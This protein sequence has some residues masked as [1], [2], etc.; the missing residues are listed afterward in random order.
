[1]LYARS[2]PASDST[3]R[4]LTFGSDSVA[5]MFSLVARWVG[6]KSLSVCFDCL[7]GGGHARWVAWLLSDL[8]TYFGLEYRCCQNPRLEL[9][10]GCLTKHFLRPVS[11]NYA[12]PTTWILALLLDLNILYASDDLASRTTIR[13]I[14]VAIQS[15]TKDNFHHR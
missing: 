14:D 5:R 12:V 11:P 4:Y 2:L 1:M 13:R 8:S 15:E 9:R 3:F 7:R 10:S 6:P